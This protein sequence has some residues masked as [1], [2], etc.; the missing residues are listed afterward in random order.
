MTKVSVTFMGYTSL[1][2]AK[3]SFVSSEVPIF[4]DGNQVSLLD[5]TAWCFYSL[6]VSFAQIRYALAE[7]TLLSQTRGNEFCICGKLIE[8]PGEWRTFG[9]LLSKW[10]LLLQP[11][12]IINF[13]GTVCFST[14][15]RPIETDNAS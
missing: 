1:S 8:S 5:Y 6:K 9:C 10:L 15:R 4:R 12:R 14:N 2:D 7:K 11:I 3:T 13:E